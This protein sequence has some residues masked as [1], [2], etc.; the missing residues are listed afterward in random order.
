MNNPTDALGSAL[1]HLSFVLDRQI[2]Q[3][4]FEQ[5]G[6]GLAQYKVLA[7]ISNSPRPKQKQI[8]NNLAQTE[9][10]ISRQ[11][12]LLSDAGLIIARVDP[13]NRRS[14][15]TF[16]TYKGERL[17]QAAGTIFANQHKQIFAKLNQQQLAALANYLA[18]LHGAVC[19]NKQ[20]RAC[21]RWQKSETQA[22]RQNLEALRLRIAGV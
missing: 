12:K 9:A 7:E 18:V 19:G 13:K 22:K 21:D 3:A 15:A 16:L 1:N 5:L 11:I 8:A 10:S 2:N 14:R 20:S 4:L 17:V 6:L